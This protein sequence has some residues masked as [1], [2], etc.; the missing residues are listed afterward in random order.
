MTYFSGHVHFNAHFMKLAKVS[1]GGSENENLI[2]AEL[3]ATDE[4]DRVLPVLASILKSNWSIGIS[5]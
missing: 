2:K 5:H 4:G 3:L 1:K